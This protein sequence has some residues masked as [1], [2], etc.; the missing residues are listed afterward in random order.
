MVDKMHRNWKW[1][2]GAGLGVAL[3][4]A[5]SWFGM[6]AVAFLGTLSTC[7]LE[8]DPDDAVC[9]S[10]TLGTFAFVLLGA[11][12]LAIAG[13][14]AAWVIRGR[15]RDQFLAAIAVGFAAAVFVP[16]MYAGAAG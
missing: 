4:S 14:G 6:A 9:T 5:A 1:R 11:A 13:F 3:A 8:Y 15:G 7:P 2:V 16:L 12:A 10:E